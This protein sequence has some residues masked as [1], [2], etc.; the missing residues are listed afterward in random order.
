[1]HK[2]LNIDFVI[3]S[4]ANLTLWNQFF[5]LD[6]AKSLLVIL[7]QVCITAG[8]SILKDKITRKTK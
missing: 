7:L 4:G 6:L 1:M 5:T 8:V 2:I 3:A